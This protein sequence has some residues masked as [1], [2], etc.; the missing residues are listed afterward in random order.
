MKEFG[1]VQD[2]KLTVKQAHV[3]IHD[4]DKHVVILKR[5]A[6]L[7]DWI[8]VTGNCIYLRK[9]ELPHSPHNCQIEP[10]A[11]EAADVLSMQALRHWLYDDW[12]IHL[13][14]MLI[15]QVLE[16]AVIKEASVA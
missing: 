6:I 2:L 5:T 12:A 1:L 15:T 8:K 7:L 10:I 3:A 11:D 16:D 14:N 13:M 4:P 9:G